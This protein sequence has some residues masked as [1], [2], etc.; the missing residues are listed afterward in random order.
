MHSPLFG[1]INHSPIL[2]TCHGRKREARSAAKMMN[3][4]GGHP[5]AVLIGQQRSEAT[6]YFETAMTVPSENNH[7]LS[8]LEG[9]GG[10]WGWGRHIHVH[11]S[12][13]SAGVW[14]QSNIINKNFVTDFLLFTFTDFWRQLRPLHTCR[15][16]FGTWHQSKICEIL[17][18]DLQLRLYESRGVRLWRMTAL[19][20]I[21]K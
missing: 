8:C 16:H 6:S 2:W 3:S 7:F 11:F 19:A 5:F 14:R 12:I 17:S 21:S 4:W 15:K 1:R 13:F 18:C 9:G 20:L 10:G